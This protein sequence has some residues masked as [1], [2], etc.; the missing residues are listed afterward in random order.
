M[1]IGISGKIGSGKDTLGLIAQVQGFQVKKFAYKLK[2]IVALLTGC[3]VEDLENQEFK[4][5]YLPAEWQGYDDVTALL[6]YRWLMQVVG[7][8]AMRDVIHNN[9][10]V[11]A[12]FADYKMQS[13]TGPTR[14]LKYPNWIIT[15]VRFPNE[16]QAIKDRGGLLVRIERP[17]ATS[18]DGMA[19]VTEHPSET[20]LDTYNGWDLVIYNTGTKEQFENNFSTWLDK[21]K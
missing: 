20:S 3:T 17:S 5:K 4:N 21:Y 13:H 10:W 2:Q 6:T 16:A 11:N 12:L 19:K 7:T 9:I 14:D 18:F 8:E 15:D 1:I